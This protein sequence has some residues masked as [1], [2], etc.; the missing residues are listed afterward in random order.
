MV[1][2]LPGALAGRPHVG[3]L[4]VSLAAGHQVGRAV[5]VVV[6]TRVTLTLQDES[7]AVVP[8]VYWLP[9]VRVEGVTV[10]VVEV[11]HVAALDLVD[12][13]AR[14]VLVT[15][16]TAATAGAHRHLVPVTLQ[17]RVP[18]R[19]SDPPSKP[20]NIIDQSQTSSFAFKS[21]ESGPSI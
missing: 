8:A 10:A 4:V 17:L 5:T 13:P 7:V 15:E 11:R 12:S 20:L 9:V 16:P 1:E 19:G 3:S 2:V 14:A 18:V 6:L 21:P